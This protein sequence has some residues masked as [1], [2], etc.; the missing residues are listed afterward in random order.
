[1]KPTSLIYDGS[2]KGFLTAIFT[3]Y[4]EKLE[5]MAINPTEEKTSGLFSENLEVITDE[6]K[7]RRVLNG[8]RKK[9]SQIAFTRIKYAFLSELPGM[10]LQLYKMF[11]YIFQ[12][13]EK[14]ATDYSHPAVLNIAKTAKKV[15]RE[16]HRMEA[17]VRFRLTK[18]DLYF[19]MI[20]PDFNVL[21]LIAKHFK[22]RYA[23]QNWII[24]DQKRKFGIYY[25]LKEVEFISLEL[26]KDIGLSGANQE[27]F[28]ATEIQ[29]QKLWKKYFDSTNIKSRA[30][31]KLHVQHVPKRYWKYLSEKS[32]FA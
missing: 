3:I 22:S 25:N 15:G 28:D 5:P 26:P 20:E 1:M 29:F 30:N 9:I 6:L 14:V 23:D 19:A 12:S 4:E 21:P 27:Y 17:F 11:E 8:I 18:D 7:A 31:T 32:P 16:K 24:Y 2:F 10:E 13:E